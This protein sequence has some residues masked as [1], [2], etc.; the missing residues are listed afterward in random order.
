MIIRYNG[1]KRIIKELRELG[2]DKIKGSGYYFLQ[3][4]RGDFHARHQLTFEEIAAIED[5]A[6]Y[7]DRAQKDL[8][9]KIIEHKR[10]LN[11]E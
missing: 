4:D 11:I 7:R 1:A 2:F 6:W 10:K 3:V 9:W 5:L 8:E